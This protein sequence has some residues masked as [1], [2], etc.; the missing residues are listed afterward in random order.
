MSLNDQLD[1][2]AGFIIKDNRISAQGETALKAFVVRLQ[3]HSYNLEKKLSEIKTKYTFEN[4]RL[5]EQLDDSSLKNLYR[6]NRLGFW[7]ERYQYNMIVAIEGEMDIAFGAIVNES[8][9]FI[10]YFAS[11][12]EVDEMEIIYEYSYALLYTWVG[13]LWQKQQLYNCG[14]PMCIEVNSTT[15]TYYLNDFLYDSFSSYS[16]LYPDGRIQGRGY[17]RELTMEEIFI[18]TYF[19]RSSALKILLY[20]EKEDSVLHLIMDAEKCQLLQGS[21]GSSPDLI[22]EKIY[23]SVYSYDREKATSMRHIISEFKKAIDQGWVFKLV[24]EQHNS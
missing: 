9:V 23:E 8:Q 22:E 18:S 19:L 6:H 10:D 21:K 2:I 15:T 4:L 3:D 16:D 24:Q 1:Y 12:S 5:L 17:N 13:F 20:A 11:K 14:I 7:I